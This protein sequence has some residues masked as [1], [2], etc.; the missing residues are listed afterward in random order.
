MSPKFTDNSEQQRTNLG[1]VCYSM[2]NFFMCFY[3][4]GNGSFN[5]LNLF[6]FDLH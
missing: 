4:V 2:W 1:I 3:L 6:S 5:L